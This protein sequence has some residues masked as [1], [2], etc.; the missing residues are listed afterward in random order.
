MAKKKSKKL[1][2]KERVFYIGLTAFVAVF[3][4]VILIIAYKP[5][6]ESLAG[7][8]GSRGFFVSPTEVLCPPY[9]DAANNFDKVKL[10][11]G[12]EYGQFE[13]VGGTCSPDWQL[14]C[15]YSEYIYTYP[16]YTSVDKTLNDK[17]NVVVITRNLNL[18]DGLNKCEKIT[19][20]YQP[21]VFLGCKCVPK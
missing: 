19:K 3:V 7:E 20:Q 11:E 10:P 1:I 12:Y 8:A 17:K 6:S 18:K 15:L 16:S 9:L 4:I 5:S 13:L 2:S 21:D 14:T